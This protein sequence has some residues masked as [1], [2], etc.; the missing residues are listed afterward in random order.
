MA[1]SNL[2]KGELNPRSRARIVLGRSI[3]CLLLGLSTSVISAWGIAVA[4][5]CGWRP[6]VELA[7]GVAAVDDAIVRVTRLRHRTMVQENWNVQRPL[8]DPSARQYSVLER[9]KKELARLAEFGGEVYDAELERSMEAFRQAGV[10][11]PQAPVIDQRI[12]EEAAKGWPVG[13]PSHA[14]SRVFV[15]ITR[16]NAGWPWP[17][18]HMRRTSWHELEK[19]ETDNVPV[20]IHQMSEV[21]GALVLPWARKRPRAAATPGVQHVGPIGIALPMQPLGRAFIANL[22]FHA[23]GVYVLVFGRKDVRVLFRLVRGRCL[24]CGY[25]HRTLQGR[26][27][28]E[29]GG[30]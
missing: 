15:S 29:C 28:P 6:R 18:L 9:R 3:F 16:L 17:S 10:R 24:T 14:D 30:Q 2:S 25:D 22:V 12:D 7:T 19:D 4:L 21:S 5:E 26:R 11:I 13:V 20:M 1:G 8:L 23:I 27:C